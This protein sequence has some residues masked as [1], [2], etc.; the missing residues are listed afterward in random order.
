[1]RLGQAEGAEQLAARKRT[2]VSLFLRGRAKAVEDA[3][4]EV[5]DRNDRR[6]RPIA[7]RNLLDRE[8]ERCVVHARTVPLLADGH[9]EQ[10]HGAQRAQLL[11]REM[12]LLVPAR[13]VRPKLL[14]RESA[15]C[16]AEHFVLGRKHAQVT[17]T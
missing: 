6:G 4:H 1:M 3:S 15:H 14:G 5:G 12:A 13:G 17:R 16:V 7:G 9:R 10:S 8:R 2:Q 11:A